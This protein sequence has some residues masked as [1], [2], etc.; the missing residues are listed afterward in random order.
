MTQGHFIVLEGVDG[1]GTTTHTKILVESLRDRGL[2]IRTTREPSDGPIG[3]M[4]RQVLTGRLV[5]PGMAGGS[6]P[7]SA[8]TMALLFAADR[9]DHIEAEI[10]PSL[11][12]GVTI[13]SD[14]YDYSSIGYQSLSAGG[15][16]E[17]TEWVRQ[18]NRYARRP[19]LT[20][21]LDVPA[22]IAGK[23]RKQRGTAA[24][25]YEEEELQKKLVTFYAGVE[26]Y[27][28]GDNIVHIKADRPIDDVANEIASHVHELRAKG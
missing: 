14:R 26:R 15:T 24:E 27:F 22:E 25:L 16:F 6:R 9:L 20:L 5:V 8:Q 19:D 1:A 17:I 11:M 2:P 13:I 23:R 28:P 4:I 10:A 12:D 18:L 21:V 7:L 3:V